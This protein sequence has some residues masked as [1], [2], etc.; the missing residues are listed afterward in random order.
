MTYAV[1]S[2]AVKISEL[3]PE[4]RGAIYSARGSRDKKDSTGPIES[5][6]VI[7]Q[8]LEDCGTRG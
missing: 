2:L 4:G 1:G 6:T 5:V 3:L 7:P 8:G